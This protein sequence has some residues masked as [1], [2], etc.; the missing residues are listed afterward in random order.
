MSR[1]ATTILK[2]RLPHFLFEGFS[3]IFVSSSSF[4]IP[5][6]F[7]SPPASSCVSRADG[8]PKLGWHDTIA[9][10]TIPLILV[11]TQSISTQ[12]MQPAKDPSK[13]VDESQAASQNA[14]GVPLVCVPMDGKG[15]G[16]GCA[17]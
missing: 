2:E 4:V 8:A 5:A 1:H 9:Y 10:L 3:F 16:V 11:I 13:P 17:P 15:V 12:I 7:P 6:R 14:S